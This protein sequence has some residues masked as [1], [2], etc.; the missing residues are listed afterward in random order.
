MGF[1]HTGYFEFHEPEQPPLVRAPARPSYVCL[2]CGAAFFSG[3]D[4][5]V[6][7][8]I[9]HV[10]QRPTL[11]LDGREVGRTRLY[12]SRKTMAEDWAFR[13]ADSVV[14]NGESFPP[15]I[16]ADVLA[17]K[18]SGF[19][20]VVALNGDVRQEFQFEFA[21]AD[22]SD[23]QAIDEALYSLIKENAWGRASIDTFIMR[24]KRHPS[25]SRYLNGIA[26]YLYGVLA[27]EELAD[28][29]GDPE[30]YEARYDSAVKILGEFDRPPAE[31]ICGLVAFHYNQFDRAMAKT[32]STRVSDISRR[33]KLLLQGKAVSTTGLAGPDHSELDA[34]LSDSTVERVLR[35][36]AIPLDGGAEAIVADA[37]SDLAAQRP[38][39]QLKLRV[40]V[41]EHYLAAGGHSDA[42]A[43]A[44]EV[45][46]SSVAENW[47]AGFRSRLGD[48]S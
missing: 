32:T 4:L 3:R 7:E 5:D 30:K 34:A 16:A 28:V 1:W 37:I 40:V 39:D 23:L 29:G 11:I 35:L 12:V 42:R 19:A 47:Y 48:S 25:A 31:T 27:R 24:G 43:H 33:F 8:F 6:H 20:D 38:S 14:L 36:C 22:A 26:S 46:H 2:A 9:D 44:D 21:L 45:R 13:S 18:K 15:D 10:R 17:S 41:A